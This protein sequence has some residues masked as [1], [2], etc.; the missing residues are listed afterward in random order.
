MDPAFDRRLKLLMVMRLV[1]VTTLLLVAAYVEAV[2]ENL[3]PI[4]PL[5][6]LIVCTYALT[7]IHAV[8]LRFVGRPVPLVFGQV[9]GDLLITTG[10][11]YVTGGV[12]TG[13]MLLY[14]ISVLAGAVLLYRR[15]AMVLAGLATLFYA[16]IV[17][18]V[19]E[20]WVP[21]QG[22][23][24]VPYL[25]P[26]ALVYSIFVTGV[27]CMTVALIGSYLSESLKSVGQ[28]LEE[29][30]GQVA[31]LEEL[32]KVIVNS[33]H[34]GLITADA[35]GHVLYLNEFGAGILRR[36]VAE[37]RGRPLSEVFRS[38]QFDAAALRARTAGRELERVELSY[39]R[40]DG[41]TA[42]LGISISPL[43]DAWPGTGG[44]G[45]LLIFQ[46]LTDIK[47]LEQDVRIKEK[48]AAVGEMAAQLA[49]EIRNPLGSI[50]GS[51]QILMAESGISPEQERL[52]AIIRKESQRLSDALNQFL[53]QA[54]P[55]RPPSGPVDLRPI[56]EEA[57]TL[58]RNGPEVGPAHHV[59]FEADEGPLLCRADPDRITQVFW[60]LARNG[61][62]AMPDGGRLRVRLARQD[63]DLVL[64][65]RDEGRG[66][67]EAQMRRMFEPFQSQRPLGTGLGLAIVYH[68][69]REERGD[70]TVHSTPDHG[71][72]VKVRLPL[73]RVPAAVDRAAAPR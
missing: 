65:I 42:A 48:L 18:A 64:T 51:A 33:I 11:V 5:Y 46:D 66:M 6:F 2:S 56:L 19:R 10:L 4:N 41:G 59:E 73:V 27:A 29:T 8:A 50:S 62:E 13:F 54:R 31:D 20:G 70:I 68:I 72:E 26:K 38:R 39:G 63:D 52:L 25:S 40:P 23:S 21:V 1:M 9:V 44:G 28:R 12:R 24:D 61:L 49:H 53:H 36:R 69:V 58:L 17:W 35:T 22:L 60:N 34:S 14:P 57:V 15:A 45:H 37:V 43:T 47:R 3:L 16:A 30:V 71:T 7:V 67:A 32:N 55:A